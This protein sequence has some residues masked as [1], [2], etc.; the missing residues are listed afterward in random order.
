MAL[1][2]GLGGGDWLIAQIADDAGKV[3]TRVHEPDLQ[4]TNARISLYGAGDPLH[5]EVVNRY[6]V[7]AL[8]ELSDALC[9]FQTS[10]VG[11]FGHP[12]LPFAAKIF[13]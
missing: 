6:A 4:C 1:S 8:V 12:S 7:L 9:G 13:S 10:R 2:L 11:W 3:G 5:I